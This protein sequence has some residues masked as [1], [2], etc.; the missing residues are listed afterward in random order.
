MLRSGTHNVARLQRKPSCDSSF[1]EGT[2]TELDCWVPRGTLE[3][4][5]GAPTRKSVNEAGVVVHTDALYAA[6]DIHQHTLLTV[7][8]LHRQRLLS[9][10]LAVSAI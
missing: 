6:L 3:T 5:F 9:V 2:T 7:T 1:P 4:V 10:L 8:V